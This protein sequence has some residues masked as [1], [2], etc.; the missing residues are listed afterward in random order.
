MLP[1]EEFQQMRDQ[2]TGV[3]T[4]VETLKEMLPGKDMM[5]TTVKVDARYEYKIL[6]DGPDQLDLESL[7]IMGDD[8]WQF[9]AKDGNKYLFCRLVQVTHRHLFSRAEKANSTQTF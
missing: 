1:D 5:C 4:D 7:Q 3:L 6:H 9:S 2:I 8:G